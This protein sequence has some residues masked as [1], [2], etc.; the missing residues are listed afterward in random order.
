MTH[1]RATRAARFQTG[2]KGT[3]RRIAGSL[4]RSFAAAL[5]IALVFWGASAPALGAPAPQKSRNHFDSDAPFREPAFFDFLV[6]GAPGKALWRVVTEFNPPST[7]NG[8]SQV[9]GNR[10]ADSIAVAVRRTVKLANGVVSVGIKRIGGRAGL[11][12]RMTDEK[13]YLALLVDPVGGDARLLRSDGGRTTELAHGRVETKRDWGVLAV[14]LAGSQVT[15]TWEGAPLLE[16]SGV[17]AASG[18]V[19]IATA[20]PGIMTFDEF[21]IEPGE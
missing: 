3:F 18:A 17:P 5:S 12:L 1:R 20:G 2:P 21:V 15:A 4:V 13:N 10:P 19:G 9:E 11:V 14:T 6:L 7:P 16:A 8:V